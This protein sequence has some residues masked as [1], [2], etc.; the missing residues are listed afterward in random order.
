LPP[1]AAK[2]GANVPA[3]A[4]AAS[5]VGI[6][7]VSCPPKYEPTIASPTDPPTCRKKV[8]LEVERHGVLNHDGEDGERRP[9]AE[10]GEEHP[11]AEHPRIG[12]RPQV[13]QQ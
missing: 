11:T 7:V 8:R 12:V 13:R 9:D 10:A 5:S 2:K 3:G 4:A 6:V 1:A